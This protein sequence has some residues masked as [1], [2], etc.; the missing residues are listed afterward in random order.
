MMLTFQDHIGE[1]FLTEQMPFRR[2]IKHFGKGGADA[3]V[4][5]LKQL[6]TL[7]T[8]QPLHPSDLSR[9]QKQEAL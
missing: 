2:G 9:E 4:R 5:E 1:L 3:V 7:E 6:D 8:V